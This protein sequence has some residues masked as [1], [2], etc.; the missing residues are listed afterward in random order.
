MVTKT[1]N[2]CHSFAEKIA[3]LS[4]DRGVKANFVKGSQNN[5]KFDKILQNEQEFYQKVIEI[6]TIS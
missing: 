1:I 4:K 3:T 6:A 5:V 2:F